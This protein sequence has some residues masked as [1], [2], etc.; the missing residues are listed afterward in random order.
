MKT[1]Q[2]PAES[3]GWAGLAMLCSLYFFSFID[4]TVLSLLVD[5]IKE[6]LGVS[7]V[8]IG[9]LMGPTFAVF[10]GI[11][12][13]PIASLADA[14]NR[15][16]L[17]V[18]GALLWGTCTFASAFV[19]VFWL[20]AALRVG[21][22]IGEAVLTPAAY[23]LI[24]DWFPPKRRAFPATIYSWSGQLGAMIGVA[25]TA[26][27]VGVVVEKGALD[28]VAALSSFASWQIVFLLLGSGTFLLTL[29]AVFVFREPVRMPAQSDAP[30]KTGLRENLLFLWRNRRLYVGLILGA[31]LNTLVP[32]ALGS[33]A[34]QLLKR[35]YGWAVS[36]AGVAIGIMLTITSAI[37]FLIIP[38][39]VDYWRDRT[40][41]GYVNI[42][43][44]IASSLVGNLISAA[45]VVLAPSA[46]WFL[47]L[48]ALGS[49]TLTYS[50]LLATITIP[51]IAPPRMRAV[52]VACYL[53]IVS[54]LTLSL[55]P[56][57]PPWFARLWFSNHGD[58]ALSWGIMVCAIGVMFIT[59]PMLT[60]TRR[61]FSEELSKQLGYTH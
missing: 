20:L 40:K 48:M 33:W 45:A 29:L 54:A 9:L 49:L 32:A 14:G 60:W 4:R 2:Y 46:Y 19:G 39:I 37:A 18:F 57:L 53:L 10:Y 1:A 17:I 25:I 5:P 22:A 31:G 51:I 24:G 41:N 58:Q 15:R 56:V 8:Q 44:A 42:N 30:E 34:P 26:A 43:V 12:G 7:D 55:G 36:D 27:L 21:L 3:V 47:G 50:G 13:L 35:N 38:R 61:P 11:L 28:H 6:T 59:L 23:S 52:T 16:L